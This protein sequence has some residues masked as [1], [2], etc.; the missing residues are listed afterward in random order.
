[1][2]YC[3]LRQNSY[4]ANYQQDTPLYRTRYSLINA[5]PAVEA[6]I[7]SV[8]INNFPCRNRQE[9]CWF[10][11]GKEYIIDNRKNIKKK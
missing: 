10:Q 2:G 9:V 3:I 6:N 7:P 8:E 4:T 1:M 11:L 5:L